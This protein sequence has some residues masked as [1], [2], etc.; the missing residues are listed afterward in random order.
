[1][2][3]RIQDI[4][5]SFSQGGR[6]IEVLKGVN[7][8]VPT[9]QCYSVLG[10]SG[11]G[12]ST[13]LALLAGLDVADSG[14]IWINNQEVSK[15]NDSQWTQFRGS[16]IGIVFQQYHLVPY[17]TALENVVL[18]LEIHGRSN[19][20]ERAK[21]LLEQMGLGHR[22]DH[23]PNQLSG[24]ECQ[25]VAIARALALEPALVLADEPSGSLDVET[26]DVVMKFFFETIRKNKMT[27]LLVTHNPDLAAQCDG[28]VRLVS[29][30]R[31]ELEVQP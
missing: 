29:G 19:P 30:R 5:K 14:Q 27:T 28:Q 18:P 26:G 22:A 6:K 20:K 31:V 17:L 13:L 8:D 2:S 10:A 12:K 1:M 15:L 16:N 9:G 7:F 11:S 25:R 21:M 3:L 24:G 4:H 23:W